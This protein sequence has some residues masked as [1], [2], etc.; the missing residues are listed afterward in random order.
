MSA[1]Y[2]PFFFLLQPESMYFSRILSQQPCLKFIPSYFCSFCRFERQRRGKDSKSILIFSNKHMH[3]PG[4]YI[5]AKSKE[6]AHYERFGA[7]GT[8]LNS[9]MARKAWLVFLSFFIYF[10][11]LVAII[12]GSNSK[13]CRSYRF[14]KF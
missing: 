8:M 9:K 2:F 12:G 7:L 10:A 11:R 5:S 13:N 4:P 1:H 14:K 3:S 6:A